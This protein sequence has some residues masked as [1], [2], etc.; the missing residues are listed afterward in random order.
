M[1]KEIIDI[2]KGIII[3]IVVCALSVTVGLKVLNVKYIYTIKYYQ[4][5]NLYTIK[6]S[7]DYK[8]KI[9]ISIICKEL[10]CVGKYDKVISTTNISTE[11]AKQLVEVFNLKPNEIIETNEEKVNEEQK[12]V[13]IKVIG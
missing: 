1:Q 6:I 11:D 5:E 12:R 7:K 2:I 4:A 9:D 8:A 10:K 3:V 13:I